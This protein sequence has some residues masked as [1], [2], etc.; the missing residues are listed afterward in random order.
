V[1]GGD[2]CPDC[3]GEGHAAYVTGN[4]A[5]EQLDCPACGGSGRQGLERRIGAGTVRAELSEV[6]GGAELDDS[7]A[8]AARVA[9]LPDIAPRPGWEGRVLD[10]SDDDDDLE[11][12]LHAMDSADLLDLE[13]ELA[14]LE[15]G[16][17][18]EGDA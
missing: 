6:L 15:R 3:R 5:D 12:E 18:G 13:H 14:E 7:V 8:M 2:S 9:E 11:Q 10:A 17:T 1:T 4:A 16:E